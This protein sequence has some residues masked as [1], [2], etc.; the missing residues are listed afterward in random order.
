VIARIIRPQG[1]RGELLAE[2]LTDFPEKF[3]ERK[4]VWLSR[5]DISE[6]REY[7]VEDHWF[8]KGRVVLH[9]SGV[10]SISQAESLT[11]FLVQIRSEARVQ[12]DPG[13]VY[14]SDLVGSLLVN[15]SGEQPGEIGRVEDVLQGLGAAPLLLVRN[16]GQQ[17]EIPFAAEYTVRFDPDRKLLEMK[18][19]AGLLGVN[20]P[21]S[22]DEKRE[23]RKR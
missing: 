23:Q 1:R 19:P 20:A 5:E 11:G 3:A 14:V 13:S 12:L 22:E 2:I 4:Q 18:L 21:L 7:T 16:A 15:V 17:Y 6:Q 8:H 9:F 10:D